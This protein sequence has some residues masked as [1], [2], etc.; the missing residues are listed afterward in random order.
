MPAATTALEV[1]G[2]AVEPDLLGDM[3]DLAPLIEA[4]AARNEAGVTL[5]SE[6]VEA[7]HDRSLFRILAPACLGGFELG[8]REAYE[9]IE[10][11]SRADGATGWSFMAGAIYLAVAGAF[12]PDEGAAAVLADPRA[13]AAGQV[14]PLGTATS[15][16]GG[17]RVEGQF[18]F[19]SG[20]V[21]SSWFY[22][23]FRELR[24]GETVML[25]NGLPSVIVGILPA[26]SVELLGNWDVIGLI[27]T[28]SVDY[29][30]P[31]QVVPEAF[32]FPLFTATP[33][34][35]HPR[36]RMGLAGL[37]CIGHCAFATGVARRALDEL[38]TVA[39]TK[40]RLGRANLIDDPLFQATYARA[41]GQLAAARNFSLAAIEALEAAAVADAVTPQVRAM[42]RLATTH[43]AEAALEVAAAAFRFS[44]SIGLRNG[45]VLQRCYRDLSAGE[46]HVFTDFNTYRDAGRLLLGVG[47]ETLLT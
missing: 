35:G 24:D 14:A 41:E 16:D 2:L 31:P 43:T 36:F 46:Q 7:L 44:G 26:A 32:T 9:I 17:W 29:R 6:V 38:A 1:D 11:A 20:G 12:L 19:A 47:P 40:R 33:R 5:C 21:H 22:G 42:A 37:T 39:T 8:V 3:R 23:G 30:V 45:S 10:E 18:G 4:S 28:G 27:G 34:R 13:V 25:D 15:A